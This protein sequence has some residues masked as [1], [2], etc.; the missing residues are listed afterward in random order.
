MT[1]KRPRPTKQP[2]Q[3]QPRKRARKPA[4]A[5]APRTPRRARTAAEQ[6]ITCLSNVDG[7]PCGGAAVWF[8]YQLGE[9]E[10]YKGFVCDAHKVGERLERLMQ[11]EI[12]SAES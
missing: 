1:R 9:K 2:R 6:G 11:Q 8:D 12:V 4:P 5:A 7:S 10:F 3:E